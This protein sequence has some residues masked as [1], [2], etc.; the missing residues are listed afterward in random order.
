MLSKL[1]PF[2]SKHDATISSAMAALVADLHY[3]IV[4]TSSVGRAIESLPTG[5]DVSVTCS[6]VAGIPATVELTERL[7]A[8]GFAA[9][10]HLAARMVGSRRQTVELARWARDLGLREVFV[11]AGDAAEPRGPY[12]GA[13]AFMR[14]FLEGAPGVDRLGFAGYPDG[15]PHIAD[16]VLDSQLLS[17]QELL[18]AADVGGWVSTQMCFDADRVRTWLRAQRDR[19]LDLPIR[20]GVPGVVDRT[21]LMKMGTRLGVGAS[22][23][24]LAKN[25]STVMRLVAPGGYDPTD[26]VAALATDA[27]SLGIAGLH[28]FTFNAVAETVAW[29]DEIITTAAQA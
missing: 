19:G 11:I 23:R 3:E 8:G 14:D 15:H 27:E 28:S 13:L 10:P 1:W 6:P 24:Y 16:S 18:A 26:L 4:P 21:R 7:V 12:E 2:G 9:V 17:K 5:A 25:T 29:H 22:V 20:L